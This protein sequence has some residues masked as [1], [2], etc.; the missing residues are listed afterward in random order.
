MPKTQFKLGEILAKEGLI[1]NQQLDEAL[2]AQKADPQRR[3]LG[4]L[5]VSMGFIAEE[6]LALALSKQLNI[7]YLSIQ[8][9]TL[10]IAPEAGLQNLLPEDFARE[11][12]VLPYNKSA[13]AINI[14]FS[15][16]L[17]VVVID[18]IKMLTNAEV[19]PAIATLS[20]IKRG[21]DELYGKEDLYKK[22]VA[23]VEATDSASET[24]LAERIGSEVAQEI[25]VDTIR[26]SAE[27]APLIKLVDLIIME[28]INNKASD[29]H[30]ETFE[31]KA[32]IR[33]RIDGIL[34]EIPPP[35]KKFYLPL[36]SRIK[37]LSRMDIAEKRLPQDGGFM[38][39]T[40]DK[41][42]DLRVATMP[43]IYGEKIVIRILDKTSMTIGLEHLGFEPDALDKFKK[44]IKKPYGL[45]FITGPTGSGKTTTLYAS[46][47]E[48]RTPQKN[49]IT[50][51][52]PVEYRLDG[53]NQVQVKPQIGLT[54][55][56]GLKAFL[57]Q[58]P[59]II[60]VGEVR[61]LETAEIC[62]RAALAGRLVLSTLHTNDAA[63]AATRLIEFG[64]E[65]FLVSS[66]LI[67][68]EAQRLVRKLCPACKK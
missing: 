67:M 62:I 64:M 18:N 63:S 32:S 51:E 9:G 12:R 33:Y 38:V 30:I 25:D 21:L 14:A 46:L 15:D 37:L 19:I 36:V 2:S 10:K 52:D 49:I 56:S 26:K 65:P 5:L 59:D 44:V 57:R 61:D 48:L 31:N 68:V 11:H 54:F 50:I 35:A 53:I 20:D 29:I 1:T 60:M 28:A 3:P 17:D 22:T 8:T 43:T 4:E 66:S 6:N 39:R 40:K 13:N 55:A 27:E 16:P 42:V 23:E 45:I 41:V 7:P 34:Y 24:G 47:K 58:D